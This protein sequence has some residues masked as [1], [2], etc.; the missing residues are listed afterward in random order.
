[1]NSLQACFES[2]PLACRLLPLGSSRK[3]EYSFM[4]HYRGRNGEE[5]VSRYWLLRPSCS[6]QTLGDSCSTKRKQLPKEQEARNCQLAPRACWR[7]I[8]AFESARGRQRH[9]HLGPGDRSADFIRLFLLFA[10]M[11]LLLCLV[12]SS[13]FRLQ[14]LHCEYLG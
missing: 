3:R 6:I 7:K 13:C 1:M 4:S 2:N 5:G 12:W 11:V 8:G 10:A 14:C 9:C